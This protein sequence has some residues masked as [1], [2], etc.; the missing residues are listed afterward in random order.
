[1]R[2][3]GS[4]LPTRGRSGVRFSAFGLA[5]L[6]ILALALTVRSGL[7]PP[8][9]QVVG[10]EFFRSD[11]SCRPSGGKRPLSIWLD[12][13][14]SADV[15][16]FNGFSRLRP[17]ETNVPQGR[18]F[19][20]RDLR[21]PK[22]LTIHVRSPWYRWRWQIVRFT[23]RR[24]QPW[25]ADAWKLF[26]SNQRHEALAI[27]QAHAVAP[28]TPEQIA[29]QKALRAV[30]ATENR[31]PNAPELL[32]QAVVAYQSVGLISDALELA[33]WRQLLLIHERYALSQAEAE[34]D[35][36]KP[37]LEQ[38][39]QWAP[40]EPFHRAELAYLRGNLRGALEA[41]DNG[42]DRAVLTGNNYARADFLRLR[43]IIHLQLGHIR[44]A[45]ASL[46]EA[47]GLP[48][49]SCRRFDLQRSRARLALRQ[50]EAAE[51]DS[52]SELRAQMLKAAEG[53]LNKALQLTEA[54]DGCS[55][56]LF[57]AQAL[58]HLA[59]VS[60][61]RGNDHAVRAYIAQAK[62]RLA[63]PKRSEV[64]SHSD[65]AELS[66]AWRV[67]LADADLR[68]GNIQQAEDAYRALDSG[69]A[70]LYDTSLWA[71]AGL[72]QI[73][74]K[75]GELDAALEHYARAESYLDE[76]SLAMPLG[77]GQGGYLSHYSQTTSR[78]VDLLLRRAVVAPPVESSAYLQRAL[79]VVRH[80][81]TRGLLGLLGMERLPHLSTADRKEYEAALD[82]YGALRRQLD[83]LV[84]G[85]Q[86]ADSELP[87]KVER[88]S[89]LQQKALLQLQSALAKFGV[90][91]V[92]LSAEQNSRPIPPGQALL[93]CYPL[94]SDWACLLA[95]PD[96]ILVH[97][98]PGLDIRAPR[99]VLAQQILVPFKAELASPTLNKLRVV[100]YG[101]MREI[102]VHLLPFGPEG[103]ALWQRP[104]DVAYAADLP[105]PG[106]VAGPHASMGS[107]SGVP[108]A[109]LLFDTQ[110]NLPG[111]AKSAESIQGQVRKQGYRV[112]AV[113]QPVAD[114]G[115]WKGQRAKSVLSS[116]QLLEHICS[117]DL[118]HLGSHFDYADS[119]GLESVIRLPDLSGL[120]V[121]DLLRQKQVPR[122]VT[123]FGCNTARTS[124]EVG[125]QEVLGLTQTFLFKG[126]VWVVGTARKVDDKLAARIAKSFFS[127]LSPSAPNP[128]QA[129]RQ[130]IAETGIRP[131]DYPC[132]HE[133]DIGAYRVYEP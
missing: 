63:D 129:L 4:A 31:E 95:T 9:M 37:L 91:P 79:Q 123:L 28:S 133:A 22:L 93:A 69:V 87:G 132:P 2:R 110:G 48:V 44:L 19:L 92:A 121:G 13:P 107:P 10:C 71:R 15:A 52:S 30:I 46:N 17:E 117:A 65:V 86:L 35:A 47:E 80:A 72:A 112:S 130:A 34:L 29:R 50:A 82:Q 105:G 100:A 73:F 26:D 104:L 5:A 98:F 64:D 24:D 18:L 89:L 39:P 62:T 12:I 96:K 45:E 36:L 60:A 108:S 23:E 1:M 54:S 27:L 90:S 3:G 16:M 78:Y 6:G 67:L 41:L 102:D 115:H 77:S 42:L 124:E 7:G 125:G 56:P 53:F 131:A 94:R 11:G 83:Q 8:G 128:H 122:Y 55:K 111:L 59:Q 106:A 66:L 61:Q 14:P 33:L 118:F 43:A 109:F 126:S 70:N 85:P 58:T 51:S 119:G 103:K 76:R 114:H 81:R 101:P 97:R 99:Q 116:A 25:L 75:R 38:L 120:P 127:H 68:D 32:S 84:G 49:G 40:W 21:Q 74:E 113:L 57:A 20:L 88:L